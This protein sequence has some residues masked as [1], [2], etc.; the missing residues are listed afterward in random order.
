[1]KKQKQKKSMTY[2]IIGLGRFG[3]A[4]AY[5][6]HDLG[7]DILVIDQDEV[8]ISEFREITESAFI[9]RSLT[10]RSLLD[11]G[12]LDCDV[13]VVCIASSIDV[14]ILTV[15]KLFSVGVKRVIAKATSVEH[16]EI[17]EKLGAE[18]VF[19]ENDMAIRLANRLEMGS[20]LDFI[21]L[22]ESINITKI[23]VPFEFIGKTIVDVNL[24]KMFGLNIIAIENCGNVIDII[25]PDYIF[26]ENDLIYFCGKK[27]AI[28]KMGEWLENH[29]EN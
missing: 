12:I 11:M 6:L 15:M 21:Q 13:V 1:M 8:K 4:L 16:G 27:S 29:K 5:K 9:A 24:R 10:K 28:A 3:S 23:E 7:A 26:R 22:S 19:P 18:I 20:G 14:S 17:L 25:A 2:G